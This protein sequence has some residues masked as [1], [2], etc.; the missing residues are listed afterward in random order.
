MKFNYKKFGLEPSNNNSEIDNDSNVAL[1]LSSANR[2][3]DLEEDIIQSNEYY[4]RVGR[5]LIYKRPTPIK[6]LKVDYSN[7]LKITD[8][9]FE[10][11][12]TTDFNGVVGG[13]YVDIEAKVTKSKTAF[14]LGNISKHQVEHLREVIKHHGLAFFIIEFTK[15][16]KTY[17]VEAKHILNYKENNA[18][19]SIPFEEFETF[20]CEI[21]RGFMPRLD[22]LPFVEE[23]N[24]NT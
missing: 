18:R 15:H 4:K 11:K 23:I 7:G 16:Y 3:M 19:N 5:A 21:K 22:Y 12:S 13:R 8:A 14:P 1:S 6:V 2:G 17:I 24:L 20:G 9:Y 10:Q